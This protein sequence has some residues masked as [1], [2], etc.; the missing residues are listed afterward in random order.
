M[1]RFLQRISV[2]FEYGVYFSEQVFA[3]ANGDLIDALS[4]REPD[5]RHRVL[6]V[7]DAAVSSAWPTLLQDIARYAEHHA[8]RMQ[9]VAPPLVLAGGEGCKNDPEILHSLYGKFRALGI[10]RHSYVVIVGGGALLDAV[11]YAAASCHRGLRVVRVPTTVLGQA[12]SGV[13]VKNGVNWQGSKNF[14]GTFA[15]PWAVLND[16]AFLRTLTPRDRIAG[17]AEAVK[18]ALIRDPIFFAWIQAHADALAAGDAVPLAY[19]CRRSAELHLAHIR[20]GGDPFEL[21]SARPLDFGHWS[22]HKLESLTQHRLRHGEAVAIGMAID[23]RYAARTGMLAAA[24][25]EAIVALLVRLGF[26]L[27]D[28]A[29]A[30]AGADGR[31]LVLAGLDE[32]REHLG[33]ELTVTLLEGI[34]GG[35]EVHTMDAA[36]I[37]D[38]LDELARADR[39]RAAA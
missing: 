19:L 33:G 29:C 7:V 35:V 36:V 32:F 5:R 3:P 27:W 4:S 38:V 28:D 16:P 34:G 21:G 30:L 20:Q 8:D 31:P 11:G 6:T 14:V 37:V 15:P 1:T 10:D 25:A 18:V 17:M 13:G 39:E 22:A 12:D 9:L 26:R 23:A 24:D 2:P